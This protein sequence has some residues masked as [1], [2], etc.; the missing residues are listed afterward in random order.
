MTSAQRKGALGF[1]VLACILGASAL[2]YVG[3]AL[4]QNR[5]VVFWVF[6]AYTLIVTGVVIFFGFRLIGFQSSP[7]EETSRRG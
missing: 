6:I 2:I 1:L 7:N 5:T 3:H 4:F